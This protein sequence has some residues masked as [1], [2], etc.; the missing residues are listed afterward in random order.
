MIY[1][2]ILDRTNLSKK[3]LTKFDTFINGGTS[4]YSPSLMEVQLKDIINNLDIK[5]DTSDDL[6]KSITIMTYIDQTDFMDE[7]CDYNKFR[8]I[9]RNGELVSVRKPS[10]LIAERYTS[11]H[12]YELFNIFKIKTFFNCK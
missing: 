12:T 8:V 2:E 7:A 9:D 11:D 3:I 5:T 4:S 10:G 6:N 1:G